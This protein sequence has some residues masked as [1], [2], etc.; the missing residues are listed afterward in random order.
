M[1]CFAGSFSLASSQSLNGDVDCNGSINILDVSRTINYLYK[2]GSEPCELIP[3]SDFFTA[4][5]ADSS[6]ISID[7]N[8]RNNIFQFQYNFHDSGII[9]IIISGNLYELVDTCG[10]WG[11]I[12]I[13]TIP[14]D[15]D[16]FTGIYIDTI[17]TGP[18][19]GLYCGNWCGVDSLRKKVGLACEL[20]V[21]PGYT[22]LYIDIYF[23][24]CHNLGISDFSAC[25]IYIPKFAD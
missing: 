8:G 24:G 25:A 4:Q 13:D 19:V 2:G 1:L 21:P 7:W 22:T 16:H 18:V 6:N 14:K 17:F 3:E 11:Y 10:G 12:L 15:A 23:A 9:K 5:F 20:P